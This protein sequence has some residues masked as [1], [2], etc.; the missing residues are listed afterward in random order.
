MG[1]TGHF[2]PGI[3]TVDRVAAPRERIR[4]RELAAADLLE[5]IRCR[6]VDFGIGIEMERSTEFRF[7][8]LFLFGVI[9]LPAVTSSAL[10][11]GFSVS[12]LERQAPQTQRLRRRYDF[13]SRKLLRPSD[14][15]PR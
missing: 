1:V 14:D 5:C 15:I 6:E 7:D 12:L 9:R 2:A 13:M 3:P 11:H 8:G 4:L 10:Q